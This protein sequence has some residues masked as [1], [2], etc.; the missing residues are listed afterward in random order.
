MTTA[1]ARQLALWALWLG[2]GVYAFVFAPPDQPDQTF[3]LIKRLST[4]QF[5]G[6]NPL[7]IALFNIMGVWPLIYS[8]LLYCD[9]RG[10]RVRAWPFAAGAF[11]V[12]AFA[13][14]P[15]LAL[16]QPNPEF[17]GTKNLW[18]RFWDSRWLGVVLAIAAVGLLVY[19]FTQGDWA[20]FSQQWRSQR[21]I[22]VMSLDFC[23]LCLL[24][25]VLLGDDMARRQFKAPK[26]FWAIALLP[27][28]GAVVY[29][30]VRPPLV[31]VPNG[32]VAA[33]LTPAAQPAAGQE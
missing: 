2:F 14:L 15:Y 28:L 7:I 5:D 3:D 18:L 22:H 24:F 33:P 32:A 31:P 8:A 1:I 17:K 21:F 13:L 19:G 4:G 9:G 30:M 6:I 27:L 16:R 23:A 25:P 10:Q 26:L 29:L 12:G 11:G 20:D